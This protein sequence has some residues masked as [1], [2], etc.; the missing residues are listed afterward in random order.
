MYDFVQLISNVKKKIT[1]NFIIQC[2]W[3]DLDLEET[4]I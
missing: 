1:S 4:V 2:V 3:E